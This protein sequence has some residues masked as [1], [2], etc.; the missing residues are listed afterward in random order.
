[1]DLEISGKSLVLMSRVRSDEICD[2]LD[3]SGPINI[4]RD[5]V[6]A[7]TLGA[8]SWIPST[9]NICLIG[10]ISHNWSNIWKIIKIFSVYGKVFSIMFSFH[11]ISDCGAHHLVFS[12]SILQSMESQ[13][14]LQITFNILLFEIQNVQ[15]WS[16]FLISTPG[17]PSFWNQSFWNL[18]PLHLDRRLSPGLSGFTVR[19][20]GYIWRLRLFC[21]EIRFEPH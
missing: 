16:V 4:A 19:V 1:M 5:G 12:I 2:P 21:G 18:R 8:I 9:S 7:L 14:L 20:S 11:V 10:Q 15:G 3:M 6:R 17:L 13:M